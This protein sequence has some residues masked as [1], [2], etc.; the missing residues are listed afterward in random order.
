MDNE[1]PLHPWFATAPDGSF[2]LSTPNRDF[3]IDIDKCSILRQLIR[4]N[5]NTMT[6]SLNPKQPGNRVVLFDLIHTSYFTDD[7]LMIIIQYGFLQHPIYPDPDMEQPQPEGENHFWRQSVRN[8][9]SSLMYLHKHRVLQL[10]KQTDLS[11][12]YWPGESF[13]TC[14]ESDIEH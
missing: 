14:Y 4:S 12:F 11:E 3:M 9:K 10:H 1:G 6:V 7:I 2:C 13:Y 8:R 5:I